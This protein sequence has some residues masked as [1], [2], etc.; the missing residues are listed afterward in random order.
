MGISMKSTSGKILASVALVGTAAAVAGLGT[1]GAFTSS[2]SASQEVTAGTVVIDLADPTMLATSVSGM[3]PGDKV[4]KLA[5]LRNTGDSDLSGVTLTTALPTG[6]SSNLLT[7]DTTHGLKI[8]IEACSVAWT[9]TTS[10]YSCTGSQTALAEA[11]IIGDGTAKA[12]TNLASLASQSSDH[13]KITTTLPSTA[14]NGFQGLGTTVNF[15]F[16]ATQRTATTS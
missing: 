4:E 16:T 14:G 13:L 5:T 15:T 1:Y 7:S 10:P 3:L 6:T 11:P 12:L 8:T 9:V 2:T